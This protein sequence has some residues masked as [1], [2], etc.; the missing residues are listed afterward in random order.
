VPAAAEKWQKFIEKHEQS[1]ERI[2]ANKA[3]VR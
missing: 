2:H 1:D 3:D